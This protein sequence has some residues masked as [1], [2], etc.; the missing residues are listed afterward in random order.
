MTEIEGKLTEYH[1]AAQRLFKLWIIDILH[2]AMKPQVVDSTCKCN[3]TVRV[4]GSGERAPWM[5]LSASQRSA[6]EILYASN[7]GAP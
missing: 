2:Q 5:L 4:K 3:F 6:S 1:Q 7:P